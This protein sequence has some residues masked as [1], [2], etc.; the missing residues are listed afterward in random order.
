MK[1][2]TERQAFFDAINAAAAIASRKSTLPILS[3]VAL[4]F[5]GSSCAISATDL[6]LDYSTQVPASGDAFGITVPAK[7]LAS[8]VG[9]MTASEIEIGLD[10]EALT[11]AS[12]GSKTKLLGMPIGEFPSDERG[13]MA[14]LLTI[15]VSE[16]G[17]MLRQTSFAASVDE[18]RYVLN[19]VLLGAQDGNLCMV[20]TD[21]RRLSLATSSIQ[22]ADIDAILPNKAVQA[23]LRMIGKEGEVRIAG[24]EKCLSFCD[25]KETI[26]SSLIEGAFPNWRAVMPSSQGCQ[27]IAVEA[28][29][30][31]AATKRA[32]LVADEANNSVEWA[33]RENG[34]EVKARGRSGE[35][36]ETVDCRCEA[37][38]GITLNAAYAIGAL[39]AIGEGDAVL[40][41]KD[42]TSPVVVNSD[43]F[44]HVIMP[45]RG[46]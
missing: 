13:E 4:E 33:F 7:R 26:V 42:E 35:Y 46:A 22:V 15:P 31:L 16:L 27:S 43:R 5:D 19:G 17:R 40:E 25:G 24:N 3:N 23:V 1:N 14:E 2:K 37:V 45:M 11:I 8:V 39:G 44:R 12:G 18:S 9:A 36:A 10:G 28:S 20:G 38:F 34:I 32:A 29:A 6:D 21:G 41:I 30:M